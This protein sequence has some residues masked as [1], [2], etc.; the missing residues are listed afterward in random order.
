[1][2]FIPPTLATRVTLPTPVT[3]DLRVVIGARPRVVPPGYVAPEGEEHVPEWHEFDSFPMTLIVDGHERKI[4][5]YL[6][7]IPQR[8]ELYGPLDFAAASSD[9][10]EDHAARV[11]NILDNGAQQ[12][13]QTLI[14]GDPMPPLPPRVPRE[15]PN[16]RAKVILAMMGMLPSVESAI[17]QLQEPDKTVARLAWNGDAKLARRGKTV[18]GLAGTLGLTDKQID[19]LFIAAEALE[20]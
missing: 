16:W 7:P 10:M 14:D 18:L 13:L 20:V 6:S 12:I 8:L 15:I 3:L 1:M 11:L 9:S 4:F 2:T 17:E 5:A 19:E